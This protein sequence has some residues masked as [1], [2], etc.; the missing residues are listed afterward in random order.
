LA[1]I[2]SEA[3]AAASWAQSRKVLDLEDLAFAQ[4]SH[5]MSNQK[6][7]LPKGSSRKQTKSYEGIYVPAL[8]PKPFAENEVCL[9]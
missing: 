6:C 8:K 2:G 3:S 5:L 9:L 7:E 4:G 1:D